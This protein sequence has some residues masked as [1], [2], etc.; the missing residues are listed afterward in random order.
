METI[1]DG[2]VRWDGG[3]D[4]SRHP[5]LIANNQYFRACNM[6]IPRSGGGL[7]T[8]GG[9]HHIT[10]DF[11]GDAF[12][13]DA[14]Q[15]GSFQAEG[16]FRDGSTNLL[17]AVVSGYIFRITEVTKNKYL[18]EIVNRNDRN[19]EFV[20]KAYVNQIPNG[21][22]VN[23]GT[24]DPIL[25]TKKSVKRI[26]GEDTIGPGLMGVYVQNRYFQVSPDRKF[27]DASDFLSPTS[28]LESRVFNI[29][30]FMVPEDQDEITAIGKQKSL[31][32][33]VETGVLTFST[34]DSIY[35]VDVR[36]DRQAWESGGSGI[37]KINQSI[38][39]LGATSA[40]SFESFNTNLYF[41][42][43]EHGLA[44]FRQSQYQFANQ[45]D[46]TDQSIEV[47]YWMDR[48]TS[49][50][51]DQC[52]TRAYKSRL[53]TT[54]SPQLNE[55]GKVFWNSLIVLHPDPV[56]SNQQ[57]S[58]RRFEGIFTGVRPWALTVPKG[59]N[60]IQ[61]MFIWSYDPDGKT[62]LYKME[63]DSTFDVNSTN[64]RVEIEWWVET[65]GMNHGNTNSVKKPNSR[66]YKLR[67]IER[68]SR[69]ELF[70]RTEFSG[71]WQRYWD[72]YHYV[73]KDRGTGLRGMEYFIDRVNASSQNR[74]QVNLPNE[75]ANESGFCSVGGNSYFVRQDRF[76]GK[77]FLT[78]DKFVRSAIIEPVSRSTVCGENL[79]NYES[80]ESRPDFSY[81]IHNAQQN[82]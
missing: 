64:D 3:M 40:Y 17:V 61:S 18:T 23:D 1:A 33:Y 74:D 10:L 47:D 71:P 66:F 45:G 25:V 4:A 68:T 78:L 80:H 9:I 56:Y 76:E 53:F 60:G 67:D 37:G 22:I 54:G 2:N 34:S 46:I 14:F 30:G 24:N 79:V 62:R 75:P 21:V 50:M 36:G 38:P 42:T 16:W 15:N 6:V 26:T 5:D 35:S 31:L 19:N 57:R 69:I 13:R 11:K 59:A 81:L 28:L 20:N 32:Q 65:R 72:Q 27:I 82:A 52:Y 63:D 77:G 29:K 8:R 48:D 7:R 41:R 51:L 12:A 70:T 55:N 39:G 49:W 58:P 73:G 44:D 43:L